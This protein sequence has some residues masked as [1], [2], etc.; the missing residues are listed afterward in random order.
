MDRSTAR[1]N[2]SVATLQ[3]KVGRLA[4]EVSGRG[5]AALFWHSWLADSAL[6]EAQ[7]EELSRDHRVILVDGPCHGRSE[8]VPKG[9]TLEDCADAVT[10]ILDSVGV[11]DAILIGSS[12]GGMTALRTA[13]R[14]P[15]RVRA[16]VLLSTTAGAERRLNLFGAWA[17][18]ELMTHGVGHRIVSTFLKRLMFG[19]TTLDQRP[20]LVDWGM[21]RLKALDPAGHRAATRAIV[22][23]RQSILHELPNIRVPTLVAVGAEDAC[24]PPS[25]S[26]RIASAIPDAKLVVVPGVGHLLPIEA[27]DVVNRLLRE[28]VTTL[29]RA[30]EEDPAPV[31]RLNDSL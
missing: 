11:R 2:P 18:G 3:T 31:E 1:Y 4:Y 12:W 7:A 21:Q 29:Q 13:L 17:F 5:P 20:H 10:E 14:A 8:T 28:F 25:R 22:L 27:P 26:R 24:L 9:F 19:K 16:L 23:D 6:W 30:P 15:D